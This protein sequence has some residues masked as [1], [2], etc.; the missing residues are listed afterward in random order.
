MADYQK[1]VFQDLFSHK[2]VNKSSNSK[3]ERDD[4]IAEAFTQHLEGVIS[5][6]ETSGI[7]IPQVSYEFSLEDLERAKREGYDEGLKRAAE[8]L[9]FEIERLKAE[10]KITK[11]LGEAIKSFKANE[12]SYDGAVQFTCDILR[13]IVNKLY[14]VLP[15]DFEQL[16]LHEISDVIKRFKKDGLVT[17]RTGFGVIDKAKAILTSSG[18]SDVEVIFDDDLGSDDLVV[19]CKEA[20]LEYSQE[21]I[22]HEMEEV[23]NKVCK[24]QGESIL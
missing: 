17:L 22:M 9:E 10:L 12:S 3:D 1:F 23:I 24:K 4:I 2:V 8:D 20:R 7:D 16:F 15:V 18:L 19:E 14:L 11:K 21:R 6:K 5:D 13:S